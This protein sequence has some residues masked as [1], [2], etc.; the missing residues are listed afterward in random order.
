MDTS[1]KYLTVALLKD[2]EI[3]VSFQE[4]CFKKQSE[5]V[6]VVLN[7]LCLKANINPLDIN[8]VVISKGPGSYTGVRIAMSIAKVM[9]TLN[10]IPLYTL[11]TLQLYSANIENCAVIMDARSNRAYIG[12]YNKGNTIL[13]STVY[14]INIIKELIGDN[15]LVGDLSLIDKEDFYPNISKAFLDLRPCWEK[16]ENIHTLTPEYLKEATT[17]MKK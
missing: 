7:D 16:V 6:F 9:C 12:I 5:K 14:E 4:E 17:Y 10:N 15:F 2:Y 3:L 11:N 8:E 1:H 13:K